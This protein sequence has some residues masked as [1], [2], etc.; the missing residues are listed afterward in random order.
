M[1]RDH[2]LLY[3]AKHQA[4]VLRVLLREMGA[5]SRV[6]DA[7]GRIALHFASIGGHLDAMWALIKFGANQDV[8]DWIGTAAL[9]WAAGGAQMETFTELFGRSAV[10]WA[11]STGHSA[12]KN[13][14]LVQY[15]TVG[16][17]A[18]SDAFAPVT[19]AARPALRG[20]QTT[21]EAFCDVCFLKIG[22]LE[23]YYKCGKCFAG[24]YVCCSEC[25]TKLRPRPS[26]YRRTHRMRLRERSE[27][28]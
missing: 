17:P 18:G 9:H 4:E 13:L 6:A 3:A 11:A 28:E 16:L 24:T 21:V 10:M 26:C 19:V 2:L 14:L 22:D 8:R 27:D 5:S 12:T 20:A 15:K 25:W 7:E 1:L 23:P